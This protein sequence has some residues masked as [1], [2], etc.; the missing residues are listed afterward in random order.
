MKITIVGGGTAGWLAAMFV[1]KMRPVHTVTVIESSEIG[2]VGAGEG[3]TGLFTDIIENTLWHFGCNEEEFLRETSATI[4]LGIKH[5]GWWGGDL[6]YHYYGAIDVGPTAGNH[7]L[8]YAYAESIKRYGKEGIHKMSFLGNVLDKKKNTFYDD[9]HIFNRN[10]R[11]GSYHFDAH[12]VGTYFKK[13]CGS[14]VINIDAKI[15]D[16]ILSEQGN[17]QSVKLDTG[18]THEADFF[19]DASGFSKILMNKLGGKWVSYRD[20]L[21]LNSA[22]PFFLPHDE[23]IEPVTTAWAQPNGWMWQIPT[24]ERYGCGY[25]FCD[26]F[27]TADQ[28]HAE[29]E[30]TIGKKIEPIRVLKFDAGRQEKLWIKNCL[31]IG[32][33]GSFAEPLEATSI[34]TTIVQLESFVT[35]YLKSTA[36]DT[37]NDGSINIYNKRMAQMYDDIKDFLVVHYQGGRKDSEFW[38]MISSGKTQTEFVKNLLDMCKT[39]IPSYTD[40]NTY[41]RALDWPLYSYVLAGLGIITPEVAQKELNLKRVNDSA[42][43]LMSALEE[44]NENQIAPLIDNTKWIKQLNSIKV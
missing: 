36:E 3:S 42:G 24:Q 35:Q 34:H 38:K 21:P 5:K 19:I 20:N 6:N 41:F 17:I 18:V 43:L 7:D 44:Q 11:Q 10:T 28:A 12:K 30:Q 27:V 31:S 25:V 33:A 15:V 16:V 8:D 14:G 37:I 4:K 1:K 2:I 13:V 29:L 39:K 32:L 26:A 22:M 40:F 23:E 9:G